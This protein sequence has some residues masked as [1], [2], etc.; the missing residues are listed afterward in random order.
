[1]HIGVVYPQPEI[2][3]DITAVARIARA[4]EEQGFEHLL[5]PPLG[6]P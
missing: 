4:V 3:G 5:V 2:N 1:M 6:A